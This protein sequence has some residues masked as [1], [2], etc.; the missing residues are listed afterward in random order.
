MRSTGAS[1][2]ATAI[3]LIALFVLSCVPRALAHHDPHHKSPPRPIDLSKSGLTA[4]CDFDADVRQDRVTLQSN[5]HD[6]KIKIRFGNQRSSELAFTARSDDSGS[7]IAGD[8][9][10]DG[11]VDLVWVTTADRRN[12]V[13]LIND[14]EGNFAEAADNSPYASELDGLFS[15]ND[16][17]GN[18]R[19]RRGRKSSSLASASF[20]DVG[21]S[22]LTGFQ[23][24]AISLAPV[25][26]REPLH[27]QSRFVS[28]LRKRGPPAILS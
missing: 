21:L 18:Q 26:A 23:S 27:V 8:I 2:R 22:V 12:A 13:V 6:K 3:T 17:S 14:G 10:R 7:L 4:A 16:P 25:S 28:Y 20:H 15:S 9:D 11:D 19:L 24:T 1:K 5:G